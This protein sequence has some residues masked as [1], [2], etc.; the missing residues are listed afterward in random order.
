MQEVL[1]H[2]AVQAPLLL[3]LV[4]LMVLALV[5]WRKHAAACLPAF[6]G[7]LLLFMTGVV[8]TYLTTRV[9]RT[10]GPPGSPSMAD[11]LMIVAVTANVVR[12]VGIGFLTWAVFAG[13]R[14][15]SSR[16]FSVSAPPPLPARA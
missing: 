11:V 12:A 1:R 16:G 7:A 14:S 6:I 3:A 15:A 5:L 10:S 2:L 9:V 13:R 8:Q 4:V